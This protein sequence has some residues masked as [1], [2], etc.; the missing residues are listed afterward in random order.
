MG[1]KSDTI[2]QQQGVP[3]GSTLG[4]LIFSIFIK[5]IPSISSECCVHLYADDTVIY[6]SKPNLAQIGSALQS[7]FKCHI[8]IFGTRQSIKSK[9][10]DSTFTIT[11]LDGT[12]LLKDEHTK[13]LGVWLDSELSYKYHISQVVKKQFL[14]H[15]GIL[16]IFDYANVISVPPNLLSS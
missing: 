8:M 7:D 15:I 14:S 4:P 2:V 3:Q 11:C 5:E 13:D 9:S 6:R 10:R 1:T 16:P 12:P